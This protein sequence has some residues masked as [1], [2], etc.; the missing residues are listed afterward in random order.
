MEK[1]AFRYR[2]NNR[3]LCE[4]KQLPGA[5][6][7]EYVYND[8]DQ[9]T[10]SQDGNQRAG[11]KW[12]FYVYDNLNRLVQ[13][14]ENSTKAVSASGVYLQNYY[15]DYSFVGTT[16]FTVYYPAGDNYGKGN[17]TGSVITVFGNNIKIHRHIITMRRDGA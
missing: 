11:G 3:N 17:L 12:T 15:D 4:W 13:Q 1:F 9:L 8:A 16:G 2:Y 6:Y 5:E 10:F 14:G 7:V